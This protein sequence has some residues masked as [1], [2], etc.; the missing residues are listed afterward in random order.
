MFLVLVGVW[1]ELG[2]MGVDLA[3]VHFWVFGLG[4]LGGSMD[5][6]FFLDEWHG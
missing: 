4:G 5:I 3:E 6:P 2:W 1:L